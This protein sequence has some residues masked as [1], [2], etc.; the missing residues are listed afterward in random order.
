[1]LIEFKIQLDG[2]G[3]AA[4]VQADSTPDP[5]LPSQQQ[6]GPAYVAPTLATKKLTSATGAGGDAPVGDGGTGKPKATSA[7]TPSS[8][9]LGWSSGSG[10]IFVI[11]PI[12]VFGSG[13][14]QT[15]AGGD[16]P[17]GDGG[18]GKPGSK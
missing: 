10:P 13:S 12:V 2:S 15:G 9:G 11:G 16:A 6:L 18:T 4:A 1:M 7:G 14:G 8:S 3:G 17:V 5:S